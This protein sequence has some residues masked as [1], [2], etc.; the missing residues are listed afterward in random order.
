MAHAAR[1]RVRPASTQG[2]AGRS[3]PSPPIPPPPRKVVRQL[4]VFEKEMDS[5]T[6]ERTGGHAREGP[7]KALWVANHPLKQHPGPRNTGITAA[8]S[9]PGGILLTLWAPLEVLD[10]W[11]T[12][13]PL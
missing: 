6:G 12:L 2:G 13:G 7:P 1:A 3:P 10:E 5:R 11:I 4:A 8:L 9:R